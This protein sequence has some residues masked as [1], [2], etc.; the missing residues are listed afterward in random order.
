MR[1]QGITAF[2][3]QRFQQKEA[4]KKKLYNDGKR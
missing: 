2:Q 4:K 1:D 3:R